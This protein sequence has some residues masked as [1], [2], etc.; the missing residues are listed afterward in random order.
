MTAQFYVVGS[1]LVRSRNLFVAVGDII[2]GYVEPG[3]MVIV[4]L[5]HLQLSAG[6][7]SIEVIDVAYLNKSYKGL[8]FAFDDP[9][10][11]G[12]WQTLDLS[13]LTLLVESI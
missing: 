7:S 8:A 4:D 10:D 1:F 2:D 5:G 12:F 13:D 3:M 6:V 9:E 11:L